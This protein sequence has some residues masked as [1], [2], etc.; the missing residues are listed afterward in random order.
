[1]AS[2][3]NR[4]FFETNAGKLLIWAFLIAI[5]LRVIGVMLGDSEVFITASNVLFGILFVSAVVGFIQRGIEKM[6]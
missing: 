1:M 6:I 3:D 5:P 4:G 2:P